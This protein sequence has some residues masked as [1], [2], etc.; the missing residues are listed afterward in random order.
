MRKE[1]DEIQKPIFLYRSHES[2][3]PGVKDKKR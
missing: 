3:N 1:E 2:G